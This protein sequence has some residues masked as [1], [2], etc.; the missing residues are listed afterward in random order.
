MDEKKT[1]MKA[2]VITV[3]V[4]R[5]HN[6]APSKKH[7]TES[8]IGSTIKSAIVLAKSGSR[9]NNGTISIAQP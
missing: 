1:Q 5:L 7:A 8:N 6:Q 2:F 4:V 9:G 3:L